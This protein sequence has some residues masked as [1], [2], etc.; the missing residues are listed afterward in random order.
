MIAWLKKL[1]GVKPKIEKS[2]VV[3]NEGFTMVQPLP[4]SKQEDLFDLE[5]ADS[6]LKKKNTEYMTMVRGV[7]VFNKKNSS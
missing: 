6:F 1:F 7:G 2:I 4:V 3:Y 5:D